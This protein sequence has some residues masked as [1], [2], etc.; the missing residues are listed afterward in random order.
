MSGTF[1]SD[2]E[3]KK[4]G[5]IF[6]LIWDDGNFMKQINEQLMIID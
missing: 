2:I 6:Q 1:E 4:Q 3:K 5:E